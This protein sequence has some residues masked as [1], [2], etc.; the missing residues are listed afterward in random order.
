MAGLAE[1]LGRPTALQSHIHA[2]LRGPG[3]R[4]LRLLPQEICQPCRSQ[5]DQNPLGRKGHLRDEGQEPSD[6]NPPVSHS[7]H[8]RK[9]TML[10]G[11]AEVPHPC[12]QLRPPTFPTSSPCSKRSPGLFPY[13][14]FFAWLYS[15]SAL[16]SLP[17]GSPSGFFRG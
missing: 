11:I 16:V 15:P 12:L 17:P 14:L 2:R 9:P 5:R 13:M 4:A 1:L 6:G 10:T 8:P 7:P 3:T